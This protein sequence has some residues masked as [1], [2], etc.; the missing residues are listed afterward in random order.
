ML[1]VDE[2]DQ[3]AAVCAHKVTVGGNRVHEFHVGGG[4]VDKDAANRRDG[5][6]GIHSRGPVG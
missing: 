4:V 2:Q 3:D 5:S 1:G 6:L